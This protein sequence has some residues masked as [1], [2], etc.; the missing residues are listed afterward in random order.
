MQ[1]PLQ[2][3]DVAVELA[4]GV[5]ADPP[6]LQLDR[7]VEALERDLHAD[8]EVRGVL[9]APSVTERAERLLAERGLEFVPLTPRGD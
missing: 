4:D 6:P 5:G 2:C 9:V 8:A 7:Y 1:V 3:L